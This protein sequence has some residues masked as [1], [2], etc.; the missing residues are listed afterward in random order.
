MDPVECMK[1]TYFTSLERA[2]AIDEIQGNGNRVRSNEF[3]VH[4][5]LLLRDSLIGQAL[6]KVTLFTL[7]GQCILGHSKFTCFAFKFSLAPRK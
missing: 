7:A 2:E 3:R 4:Y 6:D 1:A 5:V